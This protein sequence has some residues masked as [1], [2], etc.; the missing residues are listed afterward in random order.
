MKEIYIDWNGGGKY[1][2]WE[3][4]KIVR[5]GHLG[6]VG[7]GGLCVGCSQENIDEI[8]QLNWDNKN[9]N[10]KIADD[11]FQFIRGLEVEVEE[12]SISKLDVNKLFK[13][14]NDSHWNLKN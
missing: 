12:D 14:W 3:D 8:W 9:L 13:K 11:I 2:E 7:G 10:R 4:Y 6:E 1:E 5:I